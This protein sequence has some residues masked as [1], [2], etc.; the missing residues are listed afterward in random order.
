VSCGRPREGS[1][2]GACLLDLVR[3]QAQRGTNAALLTRFSG[4]NDGLSTAPGELADLI[5]NQRRDRE[6]DLSA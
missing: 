5:A 1:W 2:R 3:Q 4:R 6:R